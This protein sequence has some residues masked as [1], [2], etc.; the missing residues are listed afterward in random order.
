MQVDFRQKLKSDRRQMKRKRRSALRK[1][2]TRMRR[3]RRGLEDVILVDSMAEKDSDEEANV[4]E[5]FDAIDI[6]MSM[7][8]SDEEPLK[9]GYDMVDFDGQKATLKM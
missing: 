9:I 4:Y 2:K 1:R 3:K 6:R 7:R 8:D 5:I